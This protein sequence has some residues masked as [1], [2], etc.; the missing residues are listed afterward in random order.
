MR[1]IN[2][3]KSL[4]RPREVFKPLPKVNEESDS[5][6]ENFGSQKPIEKPVQIKL[7]VLREKDTA[8]DG[9]PQNPDWSYVFDNCTID[10]WALPELERWYKLYLK[11]KP[12]LIKISLGAN[13][14]PWVPGVIH[15]MENGQMKPNIYLHN[16]QLL[17]KPTTIV[18]VGKYFRTDQY[19]EAGIDA[20]KMK[21]LVGV[22][23]LARIIYKI[24]GF[25]GYGYRKKIGDDGLVEYSPYIAAGTSFHDEDGK[26]VSDGRYDKFAK[27]NQ[28]GVIPKLKY[29]EQI[30]GLGA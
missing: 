5:G 30:E 27:T 7:P 12:E 10:T 3:L 28:I 19:V 6:V 1:F 21:G 16:G 13:T 17:G 23:D 20:L 14:F 2:W 18:P 15:S 25:N 26:Y 22:K 9:S 29:I 8:N 24:E 11:L 4:F